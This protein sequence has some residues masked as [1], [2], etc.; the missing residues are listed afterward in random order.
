M[1]ALDA[2]AIVAIALVMVLVTAVSAATLIH[3][4]LGGFE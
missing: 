4:L 1:S 3:W 2:M